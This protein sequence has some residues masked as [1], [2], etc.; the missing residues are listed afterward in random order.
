MP[1]AT[2]VA[3][4]QVAA[5]QVMGILNLTPDS[6]SD[7]GRYPTP[8]SAIAAAYAMHAAGAAIIDIGAESTRPGATPV[9]PEEEITRLLPVVRPLAQAGLILSIDTRNAATMQACLDAGAALINDV[10]AL[11]HDPAAAPLLARRSCRVILM[12]MRGTPET[13]ASL[14]SY[15]DVIAEL[16]A[17]L[18]AR[19]DAAEH[20]GIAR[21]RILLDPG[22]GFAK[23]AA[24]NLE[25]LHRLP[26]LAALGPLVVGA[27]RKRFIGELAAAAPANARLGGSIA[28]ALLAAQ[29]G[30]VFVRVH[31]V[32]ETV[33]ALRLLAAVTQQAPP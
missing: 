28:A 4:T 31:D 22:L 13:M 15:H 3:A 14:A 8:G 32:P 2:Q 6:F 25:I 24:H 29:A 33:Q 18:L 9:P 26:E 20:A 7:G 23:T 17:E 19:R 10:S 27:S 12:H 5:T 11:T 21:T 30:A 16:R 1:A